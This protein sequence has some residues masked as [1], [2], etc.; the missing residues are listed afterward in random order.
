MI[1][2]RLTL[3]LM[4]LLFIN[5]NMQHEFGDK[6]THKKTAVWVILFT[7]S[8]IAFLEVLL[9]QTNKNIIG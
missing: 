8:Y 9:T 5:W 6:L 1:L 3:L 7:I 4:C 2:I